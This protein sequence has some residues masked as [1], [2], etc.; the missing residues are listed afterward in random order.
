MLIYEENKTE[1]IVRDRWQGANN[2]R[3]KI[4]R[5]GLQVVKTHLKV[6]LE[7]SLEAGRIFPLM[8]YAYSTEGNYSS[9]SENRASAEPAGQ[10]KSE[11]KN[12]QSA[13]THLKVAEE[14]NL[15]EGRQFPVTDYKQRNMP[16]T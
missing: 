13:P 16:L 14:A 8:G 6:L 2:P 15:E 5:N 7:A 11:N 9:L 3:A 1:E 4:N 12:L 10:I